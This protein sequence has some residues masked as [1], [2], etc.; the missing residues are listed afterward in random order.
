MAHEE[1][2]ERKD[3]RELQSTSSLNPDISF[4]NPFRIDDSI[5]GDS[6]DEHNKL[7]DANEFIAGEEINQQNENG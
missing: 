3:I 2:K 4:T 5:G 1:K 6:V 7:E